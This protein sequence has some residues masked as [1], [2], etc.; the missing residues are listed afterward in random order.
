MSRTGAALVVGLLAAALAEFLAVAVGGA[1]HG[2]VEPAT[3]SVVL[4]FVYPLVLVRLVSRSG[5]S[6]LG[7]LGLVAF[8]LVADVLLLGGAL[9]GE[10]DYFLRALDFGTSYGWIAMWLSWQ[11]LLCATI[12]IRLRRRSTLDY[13]DPARQA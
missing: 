4:F 9:G 1:G 11:A 12:I 3:I 6:I 7:D 5:K 2:W 8:A 13:S 10:R